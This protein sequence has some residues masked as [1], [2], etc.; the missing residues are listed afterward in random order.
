MRENNGVNFTT[1]Q[2]WMHQNPKINN[3][4]KKMLKDV[5]NKKGMGKRHMRKNW[6]TS[7]GFS[8]LAQEQGIIGSLNDSRLDSSKPILTNNKL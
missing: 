2:Y 7:L 4:K 1:D 3:R 8:W 5:D 6:I